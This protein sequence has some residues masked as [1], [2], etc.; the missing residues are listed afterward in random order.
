[1]KANGRLVAPVL[2]LQWDEESQRFLLRIDDEK[3]LDFWLEVRFDQTDLDKAK[4][5]P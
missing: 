5:K 3:Q 1:M 2:E 4:T